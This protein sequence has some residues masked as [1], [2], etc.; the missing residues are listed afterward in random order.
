[1]SEGACALVLGG[2]DLAAGRNAA[3]IQGM[4]STSDSYAMGDRIRRPEGSLVDLLS[5]QR[6]AARAYADAGVTDPRKEF[7]VVELYSP[8]SS[9][10]AMTYPALGFCAPLDGPRFIQEQQEDPSLPVFNPS[11]GPQAANPVSATAM[12]RIAECALQVRGLAGERQVAG[13]RRAVATGQGGAT[14][15][16]TVCVLG[17][18]APR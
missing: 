11:G 15:F 18:E 12:V 4:A 9:A 14:Q 17:T 10:E 3:W 1:M 7:G 16:S 6:S 8:F 2:R 5:L 13:V